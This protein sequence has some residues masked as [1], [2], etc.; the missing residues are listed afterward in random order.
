MQKSMAARKSRASQTAYR[1]ALITALVSCAGPS[2][3]NWQHAG[4]FTLHA[5]EEGIFLSAAGL[6]PMQYAA[7]ENAASY[8]NDALR[9]PQFLV[10]PVAFDPPTDQ[11]FLVRADDMGRTQCGFTKWNF[12]GTGCVTRVTIRISEPCT[13]RYADFVVESVFRHELGHVLGLDH[14]ETPMGLMDASLGAFDSDV[15][16]LTDVELEELRDFYGVTP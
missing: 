9:R 12:Y 6:D 10:T 1:A 2:A 5:C 7:L 8:W 4:P 14:N 3:L 15:R 16:S 11:T 13:S